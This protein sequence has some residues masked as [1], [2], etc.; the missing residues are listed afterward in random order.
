MTS[1]GYAPHHGKCL[2]VPGIF[3]GAIL[4]SYS[5]NEEQKWFYGTRGLLKSVSSHSSK[6]ISLT[7]NAGPNKWNPDFSRQQK[8]S[9]RGRNRQYQEPEQPESAEELDFVSSKNGSLFSLS[10]NS[11]PL[12]TA[13]PGQ[14]EKEIVELFRK[15][16]AQ[17]RERAAIKEDKKIETS[18]Q[19][20]GERGTVDSLL[21]LLRKHSVSQKKKSSPE[22]EFSVDQLEKSETFEDEQ[23]LNIFGPDDSKPEES[24]EP[25]P[26]PATRP[27]SN[28][29][30]KSPVPRMKFQAVFSAEEDTKTAPSKSRGRRKKNAN[31]ES[32]AALQVDSVVLD[33][34]DELTLDNP[35]EA[36]G[37]DETAEELKESSAA[38]ISPDLSS[39]KLSELRDLAK[40]RGVKG[41]SKLK[42]K[43]LV[44]LL[45]A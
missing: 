38:D 15:V 29:R 28:F 39:L 9:S 1:T 24:H 32:E 2:P 14:R 8:G 43:E 7:C 44:E 37:S 42:K 5:C 31:K 26:L 21:K 23:N 27:A 40:S 13:T 3:R 4:S 22:D 30:R 41:Y 20:Q 35:L 18:Q 34:Q 19:G 36:S 12:A 25:G 16:Q 33:G 6:R 10:S 17:L 11:K 45:S